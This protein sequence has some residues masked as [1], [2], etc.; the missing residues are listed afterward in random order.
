MSEFTHQS[1]YQK[2]RP[3]NFNDVVGQEF[4][5]KVLMNSIRIQK[6]H[7]GYIFFWFHWTGKTTL[8]RIFAQTVN[9]TQTLPDGNPC[10]ICTNCT[11]FAEKK[12]I[13]VIEID[14]ASYTGVDNIREVIDH[15][16]F[17]P[18]QGKYKIYIIDEVH[19]LSKPAFNALLKTLEEPPEHVIFLLAT[20]EINKVPDTVLSRVIRFDLEKI[21]SSGIEW[22]L[23]K[24][25]KEENIQVEEGAIE[26]IAYRAEW[27]MRDSLTIL[28]K[29]IF[30]SKLT[31]KY[32]EEALHLVTRDFLKKTLNGCLTG[33]GIILQE[34]L[35]TLEKMGI[36]VR[37]FA[38]QMT[39]YIVENLETALREKQFPAYKKIFDQF[40]QIYVESKKISTPMDI[41][42]MSLC[43]CITKNE[44]AI[45]INS[46]QIQTPNWAVTQ[47]TINKKEF[48]PPTIPIKKI[49]QKKEEP[50]LE[51]LIPQEIVPIMVPYVPKELSLVEK[52]LQGII[53]WG[54]KPTLIPLLKTA[55]IQLKDTKLTIV[56]TTFASKKFQE[57]DNWN[58]L[59]NTAKKLWAS[60]LS[61]LLFENTGAQNSEIS[62]FDIAKKIF[63]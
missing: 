58:I 34:I 2:Y 48:L 13:D 15:A 36:D 31:L 26:L 40:T 22:L 61:I 46:R 63:E 43:E 41:L 18:T 44:D 10:G 60:E 21:S 51:T 59:E 53:D 9:C 19:M 38:S 52:F 28:E 11:A 33:D 3:L 6:I 29:C 56:T 27:S 16:K 5:K 50:I 35:V 1:L 14:A 24:V 39:G 32:V 45:H 55:E 20:T 12:M 30:D 7:H 47:E 49:S 62:I 54:I 4:V 37:T 42:T 17:T 25:C 23:Q 8:A 57:S